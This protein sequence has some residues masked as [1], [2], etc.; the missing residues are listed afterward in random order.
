MKLT[1]IANKLNISRQSLYYWYKTGLLSGEATE[2]AFIDVIR[3]RFIKLWRQRGVSLQSIRHLTTPRP[4][5]QQDLT[6]YEDHTLVLKQ[7]EQWL[8]PKDGQILFA[9]PKESA[10]KTLLH[11]SGRNQKKLTPS[12]TDLLKE[13]EK[14][15]E[16]ALEK[17]DKREIKGILKKMIEIDETCLS[18]WVEL[19]NLY[20]SLGEKN[21]ANRAYERCLKLDPFCP[22]A[23]YNLANLYFKGKK[24][25]TSIRYFQKCLRANPDFP[26]AYYNFG[27]V[28]Y[29]LKRYKEAEQLLEHYV[30][31]DPSSFWSTQARQVIEDIRSLSIGHKEEKEEKEE[32]PQLFIT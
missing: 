3:A 24:F 22:E 30:T 19:G 14:R 28:L 1:Q 11:F 13:L 32:T 31:F 8:D 16:K 10:K 2:L 17:E 4:N 26:E 25:A 18:A 27:L 9:F 21:P 6:L 5:W 15:Y 23:L 7:E 29:H 20:F 12:M